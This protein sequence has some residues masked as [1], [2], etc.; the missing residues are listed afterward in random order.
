MYQSQQSCL[1]VVADEYTLCQTLK[2]SLVHQFPSISNTVLSVEFQEWLPSGPAL[3]IREFLGQFLYSAEWLAAY[4][5]EVH[6][7]N[8]SSQPPL[9]PPPLSPFLLSSF[10]DTYPLEIVVCI[11][12]FA[13]SHSDPSPTQSSR[14]HVTDFFGYFGSRPYWKVL[15]TFLVK[16]LDCSEYD[17]S[18]QYIYEVVK[19]E[20]I[21]QSNK[22]KRILIPET[23][24][25]H[26]K[27]VLV[28]CV[29]HHDGD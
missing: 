13:Q 11:I 1:S 8:I 10:L 12:H 27:N 29:G 7:I 18:L 22:A 5:L 25:T 16:I 15:E 26:Q 9:H 3:T 23:P 14:I 20:I 2:A 19:E 17:Q 21:K 6:S 28:D 4:G 24:S